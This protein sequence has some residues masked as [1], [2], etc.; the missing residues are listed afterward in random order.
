M[1][2]V[3]VEVGEKWAPDNNLNCLTQTQELT[4]WCIVVFVGGIEKN[5]RKQNER[6]NEEARREQVIRITKAPSLVEKL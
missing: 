4:L 3:S 2:P 6:R 1:R 5:V